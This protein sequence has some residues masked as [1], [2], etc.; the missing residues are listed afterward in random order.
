[1]LN[2]HVCEVVLLD[3]GNSTHWYVAV[4][5]GAKEKIQILDSMRMD[6]S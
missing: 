5:N 4:L 1:M 6:K 2:F 3:R